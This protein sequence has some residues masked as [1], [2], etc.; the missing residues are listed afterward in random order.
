MRLIDDWREV[1]KGAWSVRLMVVL[2]V[3][4]ALQ[5]AAIALPYAFKA[6]TLS[7]G[8]MAAATLVVNAAALISRFIYQQGMR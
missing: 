4:T 6:W 3:L 7:P 8:W 1:L 5:A 2:L